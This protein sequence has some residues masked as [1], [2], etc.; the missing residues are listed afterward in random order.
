VLCAAQC[1]IELQAGAMGSD[2]R[3]SPS[4][5]KFIAEFWL[6]TVESEIFEAPTHAHMQRLYHAGR[7]D[8]LR[9]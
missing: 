3:T 7:S 8:A 9:R 6:G 1:E 4:C 2:R 5:S